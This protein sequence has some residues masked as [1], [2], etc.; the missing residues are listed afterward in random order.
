MGEKTVTVRVH[1]PLCFTS[2][3]LRGSIES[4]G[5][6][7]KG[8]HWMIGG[9]SMPFNATLGWKNIHTCP[10]H[11]H[12][13]FIHLRYDVM[14]RWELFLPFWRVR[15][16]IFLMENYRNF[17]FYYKEDND[18]LFQSMK[19]SFCLLFIKISFI[20]IEE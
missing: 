12:Y 15:Q 20:Q 2:L 3:E 13:N 4:D 18:S 5:G 1:S 9:A 11:M 7:T 14:G 19:N 17:P 16:C 6:F 8:G 10:I